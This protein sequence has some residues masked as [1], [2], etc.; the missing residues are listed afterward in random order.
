MLTD[1]NVINNQLAAIGQ[2][3]ITDL[4]RPN[5]LVSIGLEKLRAANA[6]IQAEGWWFNLTKLRLIPGAGPDF[7]VAAQLPVNTSELE[8]PAGYTM[9]KAGAVV[10]ILDQRT[11]DRVARATEVLVRAELPFNDLPA[12]AASA[13]SDAAVADFVRDQA[14]GDVGTYERTAARS[15]SR[16]NAEHISRV[17][18]NML[19]TSF[20]QHALYWNRGHRPYLST[21]PR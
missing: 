18:A 16:L 11:G 20:A 14:P 21:G 7:D 8:G 10:Y 12:L 1:L 19:N 13:I 5:R 3:P 15:Y 6:R 4:T 9:R 17:A 2:A